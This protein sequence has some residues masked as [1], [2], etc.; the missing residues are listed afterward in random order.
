MAFPV[1]ILGTLATAIVE[2]VKGHFERSEQLKAAKHS[3]EVKRIQAGEDQAGKLDEMSMGE[4][5]WKDEYL[6]LITTAPLV[7][8]FL[9]PLLSVN[10]VAEV[11]QAVK[12]GFNALEA[13][14]EYYWYALAA[15]YIDTFGFRQAFRVG[16]EHWLKSRFGGSQQ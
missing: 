1:A 2:A 11:Q 10:N 12:M 16:F 14:P 7:L 6:L 13:T 8:L 9:A 3:A 4:R 15:I 5:G